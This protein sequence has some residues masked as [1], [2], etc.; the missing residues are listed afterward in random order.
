MF[1]VLEYP[2]FCETQLNFKYTKYVSYL[3]K[4]PFFR[5]ILKKKDA[6]D[7]DDEKGN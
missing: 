3:F 1:Q 6:K 5:E 2:V 7:Y 4:S